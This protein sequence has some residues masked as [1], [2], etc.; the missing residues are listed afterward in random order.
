MPIMVGSLGGDLDDKYANILKRYFEDEESLF[1]FSTD[2][3]HW[4]K[5]FGFTPYDKSCGDICDSI[6]KMDERGMALIEKKNS[7]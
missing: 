2:F 5:R 1:I 6:Q 4:G 7:L 3:C